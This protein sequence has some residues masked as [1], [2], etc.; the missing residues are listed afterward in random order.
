MNEK[1]PAKEYRRW[2]M[3]AFHLNKEKKIRPAWFNDIHFAISWCPTDIRVL[4]AI[5]KKIAP[6]KVLVHLPEWR[7]D[8]YDQ[9]YP[10]YEPS[11]EAKGF[12]K[13]GFEMGYHVMP[14]FNAIDLDPTHPVY[15]QVHDFIYRDPENGRIQG[16]AYENKVLPVPNSNRTLSKFRDK[17]VM[18]K[19]HPGLGMWRS[20]I[21]NNIRKAVSDLTLD[22]VFV[23]VTMCIWNIQNSFVDSSNV[24]EGMLKLIKSIASINNGVAVGG[25]DLNEV[26]AQYQSFAQAHVFIDDKDGFEK[27][28]VC[29]VNTFLFGDICRSFGYA[30]LDGNTENSRYRINAQIAQ[31]A[32][33]TISVKSAGEILNPNSAIAEMFRMADIR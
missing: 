3:Q 23:D 29:P 11:K 15:N 17:N 30:G 22:A 13:K 24:A 20:V 25:E 31:G 33:P 8:H 9:N 1:T 19:V 14:H 2:Y 16:W 18:V 32:I 28:E 12:I 21:T 6:K 4:D 26:T 7:T 10:N 27:M 5:A